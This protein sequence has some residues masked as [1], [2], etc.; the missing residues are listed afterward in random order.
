MHTLSYLTSI[1][2]QT[3]V[4]RSLREGNIHVFKMNNLLDHWMPMDGYNAIL[5]FRMMDQEKMGQS[6]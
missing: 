6:S 1:F 4:P 5:G 2:L 3:H